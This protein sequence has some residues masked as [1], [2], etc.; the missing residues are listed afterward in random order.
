M[1]LSSI[2][3]Y[4]IAAELAGKRQDVKGPNTFRAA[5]IDECYNLKAE[6]IQQ[7]ARIRI[8]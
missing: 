7:H 3:S 8:L 4:N 5:L 1:D 6:D 2:V